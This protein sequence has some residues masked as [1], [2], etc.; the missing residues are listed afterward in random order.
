MHLGWKPVPKELLL[1]PDFLKIRQV[2]KSPRQDFKALQTLLSAPS[3]HVWVTFE[4]GYMWWCTVLD[5]AN[6]NPDGESKSTGNFWL[7]CD[8]P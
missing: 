3:K 8:Q 2:L 5:G 4:D 1:S 6:V 7:K